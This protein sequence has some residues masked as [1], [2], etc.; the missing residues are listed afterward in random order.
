M[1]PEPDPFTILRLGIAR[2]EPEEVARGFFNA[3][4]GPAFSLHPALR[5]LKGKLLGTGA[6][7]ALLCGSGACVFAY[8]RDESAASV[9][10]ESLD[11]VVSWTRLC[12]PLSIGVHR[13]I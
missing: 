13:S 3:L 11:A 5:D 8:F 1:T 7:G 4:E 2:E 12:R 6:L 10:Q 9:A